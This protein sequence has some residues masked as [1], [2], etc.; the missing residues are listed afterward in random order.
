MKDQTG[1]EIPPGII[2]RENLV[3]ACPQ[4]SRTKRCKVYAAR[5]LICRIWGLTE[6]LKC[7]HGCVPDGGFISEEDAYVLLNKAR[8]ISGDLRVAEA[9]IRRLVRE[10]A[11]AS[12]RNT[13]ASLVA[14]GVARHSASGASE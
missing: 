13:A 4:L 12:M 9:D 2:F 7:P 5:P 6:L 11:L 8:R 14:R 3:T 10:G 1:Q